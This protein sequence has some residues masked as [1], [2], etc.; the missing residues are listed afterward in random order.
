[1]G[2]RNRDRELRQARAAYLG[3]VR[4][5]DVALRRFDDSGIPMD[6]GP[7]PDPYPW[8]VRHVSII[9]ELAGAITVVIARRRE[10]DGLRREW[11]EPH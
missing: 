3:A 5:F 10:W 7:G 9:Q 6:P 8:T 11:V 2:S 4:R 1:V